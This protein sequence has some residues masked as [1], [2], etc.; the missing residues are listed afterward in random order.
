MSTTFT[1]DKA[2]EAALAAQ[3]EEAR[4]RRAAT[5]AHRK[6]LLE[7]DMLTLARRGLD[8]APIAKRLQV[9]ITRVSEVLRER[10][11]EINPYAVSYGPT[12]EADECPHC[13]KEIH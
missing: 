3:T 12:P 9:P 5:L 10:G 2:R 13:G 4:A 8:P 11:V 1:P 6:D 7:D